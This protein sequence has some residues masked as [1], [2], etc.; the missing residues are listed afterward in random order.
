ME[1]RKRSLAKAMSWR[2]FS[3]FIT[4]GVSFWVTGSLAT[5]IGIGLL[6]S[7]VKTG[8]YYGHERLWLKIEFGKPPTD[9]QI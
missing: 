4:A 7:L 6:D 9:Y 5:A 3:I 1:T 8:L 2:F